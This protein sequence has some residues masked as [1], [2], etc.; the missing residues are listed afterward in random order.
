MAEPASLQARVCHIRGRGKGMF[1]L[2][3][4][5]HLDAQKQEEARQEEGGVCPVKAASNYSSNRER[6]WPES[7]QR[8]S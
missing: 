5:I 7:M 4:R 1:E 2:C 6:G 3:T 8:D